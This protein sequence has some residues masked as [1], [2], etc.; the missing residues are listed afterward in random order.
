MSAPDGLAVDAKGNIYAV[1]SDIGNI[2][3]FDQS[4]K[5]LAKWGSK[6]DGDGQFKSPK[7]IA[8]D[9]KGNIFVADDRMDGNV[10]KF[11][12]SGRFV[13]KWK[14]QSDKSFASPSLV[15]AGADG[16]VYVMCGMGDSIQKYDNSGRFISTIGAQGTGKGEFVMPEAMVVDAKG[17]LYVAEPGAGFSWERNGKTVS[18][19]SK[20]RIQK[21]DQSGKCIASIDSGATED[22]RLGMLSAMTM[23]STGNIY[24]LEMSTVKKIDPSGKFL[25]KWGDMGHE[26]GEFALAKS[27]AVDSHGNVYVGDSVKARIQ[28]FDSAGKFLTEWHMQ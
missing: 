19:Q 9:T 16:S 6:G 11:D 18:G 24:V 10:K 25:L 22:S 7:S 3:K 21:L 1:S 15:I 27:I 13:T 12:A 4:G 20:A 26:R 2:Q 8:V 28:K 23:D 14:P 17:V 5:L